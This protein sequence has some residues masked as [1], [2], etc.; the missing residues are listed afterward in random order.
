MNNRKAQA[1]IEFVLI[2]PILIM[3]LFAI[4]DF[5]N[6]F[7]TK[8]SLENKLDDAYEVL[9]S[10]TDI[11]TLQT[12]VESVVNTNASDDIE[13]SISFENNGYVKITLTDEVKTI[14]PGLNLILGYP[15]KVKVERVVKHA[16]Q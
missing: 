4:I 11:T 13:V 5:G 12:D 3:I 16:E 15:Y 2:L 10:S 1:L 9:K 14:T 6:I 8:S 7:V